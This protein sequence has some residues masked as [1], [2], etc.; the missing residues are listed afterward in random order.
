MRPRSERI[1]ETPEF[2]K[3]PRDQGRPRAGTESEARSDAAGDREHVLRRAA[4]LDAAH[5]GRVIEP[6]VRTLQR[7]A[8]LDSQRLLPRGQRHRRRQ[9]RR[10][11]GGETRPREDRATPERRRFANDLRHE[12]IRAEFDPLG[13][14]DERA[15]RGQSGREAARHFAG[16]LRGRRDEDRLASGERGEIADDAH[17]LGQRDA[18]QTRRAPA[19]PQFAHRLAVTPP[20]RDASPRARR[21]VG[22]REAPGPGA[23]DAHAPIDRHAAPFSVLPC[24]RIRF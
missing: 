6:Q 2:R 23:R 14:D 16:R 20:E 5:V 15:R 21:R 4:D 11:V 24:L 19:E 9:A 13:A 8:E 3:P 12:Q 1:A 18:R 22:E 10:D 17:S 7:P